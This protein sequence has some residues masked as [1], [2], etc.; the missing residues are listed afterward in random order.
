MHEQ[1][2]LIEVVTEQ[3]VA[4]ITTLS[5]ELWPNSNYDEEKSQWEE[6]MHAADNYC[7][8]AKIHDEYV[9]FIHISIRYDYVEGTEADNTAYLEGIYVS[10]NYRKKQI[11]TALLASGEA[12]AKAKGLNQLA[13]DTEIENQISQL[14]HQQAGFTEVSRLVCFVKTI[15]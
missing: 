2:C 15:Q 5:L 4:A 13:S 12:W 11:A 8:V 9:G 1:T 7:A 10:P 3:T 14:F 6:L